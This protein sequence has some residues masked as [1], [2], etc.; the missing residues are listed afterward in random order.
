MPDDTPPGEYEI[1][2]DLVDDFQLEEIKFG[3]KGVRWLIKD[4]FGLDS[5]VFPKE[6]E[7]KRGILLEKFKVYPSV[8]KPIKFRYKRFLTFQQ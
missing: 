1:R 7:V 5:T 8:L 4:F 6:E 3:K 2:L